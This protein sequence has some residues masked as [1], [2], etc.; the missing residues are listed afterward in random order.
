MTE[1]VPLVDGYYGR[2]MDRAAFDVFFSEHV[3]S[4]FGSTRSLP[5]HR[6]MTPDEREAEA[7]LRA[8]M[9]EPISLYFGIYTADHE[10]IGWS[11]GFQEGSQRFYMCNTGILA[12]HRRQG[13]YKALLPVIVNRVAAMGF[14]IIFSRHAMTNNAVIIP[15][16]RAGFVI[17]NFELSDRFGTLVHLSYFTNAGRRNAM[18]YQCGQANLDPVFQ[19]MMETPQK[20]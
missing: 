10:Q 3:K 2:E 1:S 6:L 19:T 4:V 13:L 8:R 12:A 16:L 18:D 14:Q 7:G 17:S 11:Y 9:G 15:K 5:V 20:E